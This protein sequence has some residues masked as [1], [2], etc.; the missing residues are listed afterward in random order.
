MEPIPGGFPPA[1]RTANAAQMRVSQGA[2]ATITADP[3]AIIGPLVGGA[4]NGVI[5]F[6]VPSSCGSDPE[7]CCVNN[8][9]QPTCG[10]LQ[11][12][13]V[14]R[15]GDLPRLELRPQQGA[16]RLDLTIRARVK[17]QMDLRVTYSGIT[18]GVDLDTA[19]GSRPHIQI[20]GQM[21]FPQ[22]ATTMTTRLNAQNMA[23]SLEND[24]IELNGGFACDFAGAFIGT[25]RGLLEDQ[26][27]GLI[28]DT[29]NEQT[30]KA[31]PSGQ[32][33]EC[34]AQATAC[35]DQVCRVGDRCMQELG[36]TGRLRGTS[37]FGSFSP[38]TT[39]ALDL[40]EVLGGYAQT[41]NNGLSFGMLGGM[42]SGGA[43]RDRCGPPATAPAKVTIQPSAFFQ[44]NSRPDTGAPFHVA[45]GL[46]ASQLAQLAYAGYEG[47]LFCLTISGGTVEQLSTDT[48]ALIARSLGNLARVNS[49]MAVGLRPQSPPQITL[50]K[51]TFMTDAMGN[52]TLVEPLLDIRFTALEI[53]FFA[54]ID[55]QYIR[56]FTVVSD[57]QLPIGLQVTGMGELQPVLGEIDNAFT[58][59]SVK[60]NEAVTEDPAEMAALFPTLLNLVLPQLSGALPSFALPELGGLQL[61][62]TDITAVPQVVGGADSSYLA[63]FANLA[64][65][66]MAR[67]VETHVAL[68][69]IV[70]ADAAIAKNPRAWRGAPAS[71]RPRVG[72]ALGGDAASLEWSY[73]IDGGSWSPWATNAQPTLQSSLFWLPGTH[74]IEVRARERGRPETIDPTP[75]A[76]EVTLGGATAIGRKPFHGQPG[77]AGCDCS[78]GGPGAAGPFA[79]VLALLVMPLR[80][81]RR[82]ARELV[83]GARRLGAAAWLAALA[84]LPGC[85]CG[86][87]KC[88][89]SEC[90]PGEVANKG[91]GPWTSIAADESRVMVATYDRGLGDLVAVDVTDPDAP[92]YKVVDGVPEGTPV[93]DPS[94]YRGGIEEPGPDVGAW[95]AIAIGDGRA[96]IAY[97][98]REALQLKFAFEEQR[99]RWTSYVVDAGNGEDVGRY[100][101]I[102]LDGQG[103][104][105]VAYLALGI[106]NG[107]GQ[108]ITELRLARASSRTPGAGDWT[109]RVIASAPGTCGGACGSGEACIAGMT[110][111]SCV[112][113]DSSCTPAC[114]DGEACVGG[115][116]TETIAE[117]MVEDIGTGTGLFVSLVTLPD[118]RLAA[119]YYDRNARALKLA[120][121]G[122]AGGNDFTEVALDAPMIG[123]RGMWASAA[124]DSAGVVH[125]AYQDAIGD[126][127]MY[128]TWNGSPGT[129]ELV[130]D[131]QRQGDRTHPVGAGASLYFV[132]GAPVIAYQDGLTSDVYV[133]TKPGTWTTA[134]IATGPVLDG[135]SIAGTGA[136]GVPYIA[137]HAMEPAATP[138][139]RLAVQRQ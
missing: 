54:A 25:V 64:P 87:E 107:A 77:E 37:L 68:G 124:V 6:N 56:T 61:T 105:A 114:G 126:Q 116:C 104:P 74:R 60:N 98:D 34:G 20:D 132:G 65:P 112:A 133:A 13:L 88:G 139:S 134:P 135:F 43:P 75:A 51:N 16:S 30:C 3:A 59:I 41:D 95:T 76:I 101:S 129:P 7:V 31:C 52:T 17:T 93:F 49:P 96:M 24:D 66:M 22:D 39:G 71:A 97:Q 45:F 57:V 69:D 122:S 117:S 42:V 85:S 82:R 84:A 94:G 8:V 47:G 121:E 12:D 63:I 103:N 90:M 83:R 5:T 137:W 26:V 15:A 100:A 1:E 27:A 14:Q 127:L 36:I 102:T 70:E 21:A 50:G 67:P 106:D 10:P 86:S 125:V 58:N 62:V 128:T 48:L 118:G 80:R 72:L 91:L 4:M 32:V 110:G 92:K 29:I 23:V 46:H 108:R 53:D 35:T 38:G 11:I 78:T 99:N 79:L 123:D 9:P 55:G 18:C 89:D 120:A 119:A 28:Q 40:Y 109:T 113:V 115:A 81:V 19:R 138:I 136:H 73:R 33:A 111:E 130:D 44:G 2:L 131:G